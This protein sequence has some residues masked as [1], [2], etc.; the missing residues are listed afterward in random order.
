ML[1]RIW[2]LD[3]YKIAQNMSILL[4][5]VPQFEVLEVHFYV[6]AHSVSRFN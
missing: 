5:F 3:F 4:D 6:E 1:R 2:C